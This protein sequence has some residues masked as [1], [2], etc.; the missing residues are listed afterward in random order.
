[1]PTS[2]QPDGA[3]GENHGKSRLEREIEEILE[4][5]EREHPLPPPTPIRPDIDQPWSSLKSRVNVPD[6]S[7]FGTTMRRMLDSMPLFVALMLAILAWMISDLSPFLANIVA[8]AS[9]VALFWPI[10][11]AT[12]APT[13]MEKTWRG[14]TYGARQEPPEGAIRIREWLR[15]KGLMK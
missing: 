9:V 11:S 14:Q 10:I 15:R 3:P 6:M 5:T 12:R 1:M 4:K 2:A 7:D 8:I 13:P